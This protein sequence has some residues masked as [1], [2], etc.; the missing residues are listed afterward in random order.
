MTDLLAEH[1]E[2]VGRAA[3][4]IA[5]LDRRVRFCDLYDEHGAKMYHA[6]SV[7][8][9]SEI[10]ELLRLLKTCSGPV[11]ELAAGSGR[12]ALPLLASG[13]TVTAL[14]NSEAMLEIFR[15]RLQATP[16]LA[17]RCELVCASMD[18]FDVPGTYDAIILGST[19]ITLLTDEERSRMFDA[20]ARHLSADGVFYLS[21]PL[22]DLEGPAHD[23]HQRIDVGDVSVDLF[24]HAEENST[25]RTVT[26]VGLDQDNVVNVAVSEPHLI[27][28]ARVD[29]QLVDAGFLVSRRDLPVEV[30]GISMASELL[31]LTHSGRR[32]K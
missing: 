3:R 17:K 4:Y 12:L 23:W 27:D 28:R 31:H 25:R 24:S 11:L 5:S 30:Q 13:H 10:F 9:P 18:D 22:Y 1:P 19:S 6:G 8:D 26:C 21:L 29:E 14:D 15:G 7:M 32:V 20:V 2:L 16:D